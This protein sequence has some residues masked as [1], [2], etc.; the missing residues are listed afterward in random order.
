MA[1]YIM[2]GFEVVP[3]DSVARAKRIDLVRL[4]PAFANLPHYAPQSFAFFAPAHPIR[5]TK[6]RY[7]HD[8]SFQGFEAILTRY[9]EEE[10]TII[11]LANLAELIRRK[12]PNISRSSY[13]KNSDGRVRRA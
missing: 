11:A 1:N 4:A 2:L 7:G 6:Q 12:L 5:N 8:G 13:A 9:I 3:G 10:L